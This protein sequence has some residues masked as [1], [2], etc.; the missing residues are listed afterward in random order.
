[1]GLHGE[2]D[3]RNSVDTGEPEADAIVP[4]TNGE[5][6]HQTN[7][8][9]PTENNRARTDILR[10][11]VREHTVLADMDRTLLMVGG[12][13]I[14]FGGAKPSLTGQFSI[15]SNI[16]IIPS[17][18][19]GDDSV[20]YPYTASTKATLS[21]LSGPDGVLFTSKY[22][23]WEAP[24]GG[25]PNIATEANK[26]SVEIQDT[27][28][29][30]VDV[31]GAT[32]EENNILIGIDDGT[33]TIQQVV[34]AVNADTTANKLVVASVVGTAGNACPTFSEAEWGTDYSAR[35][36]R[37]GAA[38]MYHTITNANLAAFFSAH[39]DNPLRKGDTLA[40]WYDK[41]V[42]LSTTPADDGRFQ[43]TYENT[44]TVIPSTAFFNTR[45]E[46]EKIPNCIP[47]CRCVDDTTILFSCG[48]YIQYGTPASLFFDSVQYKNA[49]NGVL[50]TP[51]N[52]DRIGDGTDHNPPTT[53]RHALDNADGRLDEVMTE[54]ENA[55]TNGFETPV[56][57]HTDLEGRI[58][59]IGDHSTM[60]GTIISVGNPTAVGFDEMYMGS[61]G[62]ADAITSIKNFATYRVGGTIHLWPGGTLSSYQIGATFPVINKPIHFV[63][64]GITYFRNNRGLG[65]DQYVFDFAAG[66]DGS[67]MENIHVIEDS[68][69]SNK[70]LRLTGIT[71]ITIRNCHFIGKVLVTGCK[72]VRFENCT[73]A[74]GTN[75]GGTEFNAVEVSGIDA[76]GSRNISFKNC[77]FTVTNTTVTT[78]E[79]VKFSSSTS[80]TL[81]EQTN[82]VLLEN[83]YVDV[84]DGIN[85]MDIQNNGGV[86]GRNITFKM[87]PYT[88][89][90]RAL[91]M[92]NTTADLQRLRF[93]LAEW[94]GENIYGSFIHITNAYD[95]KL[96]GVRID[97]Q[98]CFLGVYAAGDNP[99]YV[100]TGNVVVS[101]LY[102][103]G[104]IL[105]DSGVIATLD[106]TRPIILI[107]GTNGQKAE[108]RNAKIWAVYS[109]PSAS[110]NTSFTFIGCSSGQEGGTGGSI[111][112]DN[113]EIDGSLITYSGGSYSRYFVNQLQQ[114]STVRNCYF[115]DGIIGAAIRVDAHE[116]VIENNRFEFTTQTTQISQVI[117]LDGYTN[118]RCDRCKISDNHIVVADTLG[119]TV[120]IQGDGA[121]NVRDGIFSNNTV[122]NTENNTPPSNM[123]YFNYCENWT[124]IGNVVYSTGTRIGYS[125]VTNM[126][127]AVGSL[128]T[129]NALN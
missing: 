28:S 86:T 5:P 119:N 12:G 68:S 124:V 75:T 21:V 37:G 117:V 118:D 40:I 65:A 7:L 54:V 93:E 49:E 79:V 34:D 53:I 63:S 44:A 3:F 106:P 98:Q 67:T 122:R 70:A 24:S 61:S 38:G 112:I 14:T 80:E 128:G 43:S 107:E 116:V 33:T 115:H 59:R 15:G 69:P 60:G 66:A 25:D 84:P 18:T 19:P 89:G 88:A 62:L 120:D 48:A 125:N 126:V 9:R 94:S 31:N 50:S 110:G 114:G 113:V 96:D 129:Y 95:V 27:G 11:V 57:S 91:T 101:N 121:H 77:R 41:L 64:P 20:G 82:G 87:R 100:S 29:L 103:A 90:T 85:G 111:V 10:E 45:R 23:Q 81:D 26:I 74:G 8:R 108:L 47:I 55:R 30:T 78:S 2:V 35:F 92:D 97:T 72:R 109:D 127:P 13:V 42:D 46:P 32:G 51:L 73:F 71:D 56:G 16:N 105:P 76:N 104:I 36:L 52:W 83:C 1:M 99:I 6:A 4:I 39:A 22:K 102:W 17:A 123:V 58:D